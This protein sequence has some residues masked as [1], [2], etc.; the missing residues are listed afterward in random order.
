MTS[1]PLGF[2]GVVKL[3]SPNLPI[4]ARFRARL[5]SSREV[6]RSGCF[7][8]RHKSAHCEASVP[9]A[10]FLRLIRH[11]PSRH[12]NSMRVAFG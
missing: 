1:A 6:W 10:H 7:G 4:A 11:L 12:F 2:L 9:T 5:L 3:R 8:L